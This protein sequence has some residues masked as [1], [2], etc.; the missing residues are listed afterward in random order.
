MSDAPLF[1]VVLVSAGLCLAD[2]VSAAL[3]DRGGGFIYDDVLNVT[4][5]QETD[6]GRPL[7]SDYLDSKALV[8]SMSVFD[9]IRQTWWNDWRLPRINGP[10]N[11]VSYDFNQLNTFGHDLG[12]L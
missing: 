5:F 7:G 9:P 3:I 10:V 8:E 2:T 4:W 6:I 11:G 12:N 1:K